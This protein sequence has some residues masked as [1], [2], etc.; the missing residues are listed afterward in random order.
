M[1]NTLVFSETTEWMEILEAGRLEGI[2][3]VRR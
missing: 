3:S 2:L 1:G